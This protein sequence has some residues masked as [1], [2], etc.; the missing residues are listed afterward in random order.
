MSGLAAFTTGDAGL[1]RS[2]LV[3]GAA[4]M[5][6]LAA[7]TAGQAGLLSAELVRRAFFVR[8]PTAATGDVALLDGVHCGEPSAALGR[9]R[10]GV[11]LR[12][13]KGTNPYLIPNREKS[14]KMI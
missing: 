9:F 4:A 1:F 8:G 5:S 2:E 6:G 7:F 12:V 13:S 10:H 11:F 3:R 14:T